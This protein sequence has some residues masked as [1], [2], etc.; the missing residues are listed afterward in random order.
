MKTK[1]S[2]LLLSIATLLILNS[3]LLFGQKSYKA[4]VEKSKLE[5]LGEKVAGEHRG[6]IKLASGEMELK[7]NTLITI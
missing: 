4:K 1:K 6:T 5:W 2:T 3:H 7:N